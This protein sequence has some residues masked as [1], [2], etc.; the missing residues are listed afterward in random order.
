MA[1]FAPIAEFV[2]VRGRVSAEA[3]V[4]IPNTRSQVDT[5]Q[6]VIN[7]SATD[8]VCLSETIGDIRI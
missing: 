1:F 5:T 7:L 2:V 3:P 6:A 8:Q 4:R